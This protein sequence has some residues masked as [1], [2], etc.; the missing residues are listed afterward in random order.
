MSREIKFRAWDEEKELMLY[1]EK[2]PYGYEWEINEHYGV[3]CIPFEYND[4]DFGGLVCWGEHLPV[5]QY[6]G[7]KDMNGKEIYEGDVVKMHSWWNA[8]GPAGYDSDVTVV[9]FDEELC[10]FTPM[11]NYDC[12]CGVYHS[13]SKLE[14]IGNIYEN[15][16]LIK[17]QKK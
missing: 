7:L 11:C 10:G 4:D 14:V 13:A 17:E 5:M 3:I 12:D 9:E 15:P 2:Q 16:E 6:T 1:S 8:F